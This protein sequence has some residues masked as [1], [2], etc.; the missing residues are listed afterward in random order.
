MSGNTT[1]ET[2]AIALQ[3]PPDGGERL[4]MAGKGHELWI[5]ASSEQTGGSFSLTESTTAAGGSVNWHVHDAEDEAF[6]VLDGEYRFTIGAD[7]LLARPG[8][9]VFIPRGAPHR[10]TAGPQNVRCLTIFAPGGY[11]GAFREIASAMADEALSPEFWESLGA[12]HRT[13]FLDDAEVD[14]SAPP[15]GFALAPGA[16][17]QIQW[18]GV[19]LSLLAGKDE[20]GGS[21]TLLHE[22]CH[23]V[24]IPWHVH[25]DDEAF[26]VLEGRYGVR[27]GGETLEGGPGTFFFLPR[28]VPHQQSVLSD[29]ARKL[30]LFAPGGF[31]GYF[32]GMAEAI[33][34]G[35]ITPQRVQEI[36]RANRTRFIE[37]RQ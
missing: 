13:R 14:R 37:E 20:T 22:V 29:G 36:A 15:R 32:R 31:E 24:T 35:A 26:Y 27:C 10:W 17:E 4:S 12:R 19:H 18:P 2:D 3:V 21:F 7:E 25:E 8:E 34:G 1:A 6:Y 30:A 11:E 33:N 9:F 28:N 16:A 23:A 5:K